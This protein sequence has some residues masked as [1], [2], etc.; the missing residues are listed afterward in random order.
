[1]ANSTPKT[2]PAGHGS[3]ADPPAIAYINRP[4]W[5]QPSATLAEAKS[6]QTPKRDLL[7]TQDMRAALLFLT[8]TFIMLPVP[9]FVNEVVVSIDHAAFRSRLFSA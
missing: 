8:I 2:A 5:S 6:T 4:P 9:V 3:A 7:Q 1:M